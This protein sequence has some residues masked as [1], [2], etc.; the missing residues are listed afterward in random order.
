MAYTLVVKVKKGNFL[1]NYDTFGKMDPFIKVTVGN[2]ATSA[3]KTDVAQ[4]QGKTPVWKKVLQFNLNQTQ[5]NN[6]DNLPVLFEAYDEDVTSDEYIGR[7]SVKL[8]QVKLKVGEVNTLTMTDN[9]NANVGTIDVEFEFKQGAA[10]TSTKAGSPQKRNVIGT[11]IVKPGQ[12]KFESASGLSD[13]QELYLVFIHGDV[14]YQS[15]INE[16]TARKPLF[17]DIISFQHFE[18][19]EVIV[20]CFDNDPDRNDMIGEGTINTAQ[21]AKR[22][23]VQNQSVS[24]HNAAKKTVGEINIELEAIGE[25]FNNPVKVYAPVPIKRGEYV[26]KK[27]KYSNPDK[28]KKNLRVRTE[29]KEVILVKTE[30]L[31]ILPGE[32]GEIRFKFF[33]PQNSRDKEDRCRIDVIVEDTQI[34]EESLLFKVKAL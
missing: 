21:L 19:E 30:H 8:S 12:G 33:A 34:V 15:G 31:T 11:L 9:K 3:Q 28:F 25:V 18:N 14:A 10:P 29:N 7:I 24:L 5:Y 13:Y 26:S 32:T 22:G 4:G 20:R 23:G 2:D 1:K 16:G 6:L 17:R 27:I